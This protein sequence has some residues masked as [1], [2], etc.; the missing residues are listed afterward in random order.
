MTISYAGMN[1][2]R[3]GAWAEVFKAMG[4]PTRLA[5][6]LKL[7]RGESRFIGMTELSGMLR[8]DAPSVLFHLT[9]LKY[10]GLVINERRG[11]QV[12]CRVNPELTR[13][14]REGLALAIE[15]CELRFSK[16]A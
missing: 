1:D 4:D 13:K 3:A 15:G 9:R 12:F 5:I 8:L 7:V 11:Q 6:L 16:S 14:D 10:A 2:D